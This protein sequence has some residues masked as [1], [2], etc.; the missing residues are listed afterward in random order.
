MKEA[1][2]SVDK[3]WQQIKLEAPFISDNVYFTIEILNI[4]CLGWNDFTKIFNIFFK[5]VFFN[6][7]NFNSIKN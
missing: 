2:Y 6:S 7:F 5:F 3:I 1:I 4:R